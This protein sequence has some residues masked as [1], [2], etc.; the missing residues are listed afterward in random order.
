MRSLTAVICLRRGEM[1][2]DGLGDLFA[3]S[4]GQ[5][6]GDPLVTHPVIAIRAG[7]SAMD[8]GNAS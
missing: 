4:S 8:I 1:R 5:M 3:R 2:L 6:F 7:G